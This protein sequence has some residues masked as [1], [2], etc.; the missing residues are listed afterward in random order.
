MKAPRRVAL[1][2]LALIAVSFDPVLAETG[3]QS[4]R[5]YSVAAQRVMP[6]GYCF[7]AGMEACLGGYHMLCPCLPTRLNSCTWFHTGARCR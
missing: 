3:S 1:L 4:E 5:P 2:S 7:R 6:G